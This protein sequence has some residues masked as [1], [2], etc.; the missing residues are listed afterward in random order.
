VKIKVHSRFVSQ[1]TIL[2]ILLVPCDLVTLSDSAPELAW[3]QQEPKDT[4]IM[5]GLAIMLLQ[6]YIICNSCNGSL[7]IV[8]IFTHSIDA[9]VCFTLLQDLLHSVSQPRLRS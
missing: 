2:A 3:L 7:V 4:Y 9:S 8:G 5:L 1:A 6:S